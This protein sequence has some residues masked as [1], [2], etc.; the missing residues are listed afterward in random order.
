MKSTLAALAAVALAAATSFANA[1]TNVA[2]GANVTTTGGGFG[3]NQ[4]WSNPVLAAPSTVT[5]GVFLPTG[6]QWDTGTLF[7]GGDANDTSDVVTIHL[8]G[9]YVV[10]SLTLQADNNDHYHVSY[11][12]AGGNWHALATID[13]NTN[14][15]WGLG[16]GYASFASVTATAFSIT[17][18]GDQAYA[19]SEFQ[20]DGVR[21]AVPEPSEALMLLAGV[22]ALASVA[23]RRAR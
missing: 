3:N 10:D 8:G 6:Q 19:V 16:T 17:A 14:S 22:A 9:A 13:P 20:A 5:D 1:S 15:S 2:L 21:A 11:E 18:S 7:W 4:G 12:D 23:R